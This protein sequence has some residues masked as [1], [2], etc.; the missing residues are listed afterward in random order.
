MCD[1]YGHKCSK[2]DNIIEMHLA[3]YNTDQSEIE[4]FCGEHIPEDISRG[5]I[6]K[7][8][9]KELACRMFVLCKTHNAV[10]NWDGNHPNF[11]ETK[12]EK[13][14]GMDPF[15]DTILSPEPTDPSRA[16][17]A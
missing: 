17:K 16:E 11:C 14:F 8:G 2:C 15:P 4:V 13:V 12:V 9:D 10:R 7:Y 1:I 5:T 6:W 3:D